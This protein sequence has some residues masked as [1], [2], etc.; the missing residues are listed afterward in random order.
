MTERSLNFLQEHIPDNWLRGLW[1]FFTTLTVVDLL[2]ISWKCVTGCI[3]LFFF[4][5]AYLRHKAFMRT[6]KLKQEKLEQEIGDKIL[7][8]K[9]KHG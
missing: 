1:A 4:Y 5:L 9:K 6:E 3:T 2:S 8:N 7:S